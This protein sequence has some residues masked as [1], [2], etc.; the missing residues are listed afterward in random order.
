MRTTQCVRAGW[1]VGAVGVCM[2]VAGAARADVTTERPGSI[3]IFPKVVADGT[4]DTVIQISNT[5]NVLDQARCFYINGQKSRSGVAQCNET[6]FLI[7]LTKQQPTFWLASTGRNPV[8]YP[9]LGP[10]LVPPVPAGFTGALVCVEV[11]ASLAPV[12]MNALKGEATLEGPGA[13]L[14]KYNGIAFLG[15]TAT[16]ER[17]PL[18]DLS[19]DGVEYNA[20]PATSRVNFVPAGA[21]DPI[22]S[23]IG[24]AGVCINDSAAPCTTTTDCTTGTCARFTC[25]GGRSPGSPCEFNGD[26]NGGGSCTGPALASVTTT[27]TVLP[28]NL[29]MNAQ[30]PTAVALNFNGADG[31]EVSLS[32]SRN[33]SCWD[34][35]NI[36]S[37]LIG[38]VATEFATLEISSGAGGPVL[39]VVQTVHSDSIG[40]NASA[41]LNTH[42]GGQCLGACSGGGNDGKPCVAAA[43]CPSGTCAGTIGVACNSNADCTPGACS[44]PRFCVGGTTPGR[45]CTSD[46]NC[47]SGGTCPLPSA[48]I[49]LPGA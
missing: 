32:G 19:L 30:L 13:D 5:S 37:I 12:K 7:S 9:G 6:D 26:C 17:P 28:C 35:F 22:I 31:T 49:R 42:M 41:A 20:C 27:V 44:G 10:G 34:S 23:G 47:G 38:A 2:L 40:N 45:A 14:S 43:G 29:D 39:A 1:L 11:D 4:R 33:I 15:N 8:G 25:V 24:N 48:V 36:D 46:A 18:N 16:G 3:L 21:P